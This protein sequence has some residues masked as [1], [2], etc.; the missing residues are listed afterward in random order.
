ML[1]AVAALLVSTT[2][3]NAQ[4]I[5]TGEQTI[6]GRITDLDNESSRFNEYRDI[7]DG[8]YVSSARIRLLD[9]STGRY[10]N[11]VG[12]NL[13][14]D[15][16]TLRV[17]LGDY[18]ND[19]K[20]TFSR[21]GRPHR[22][23]NR[24]MTPYIYQGDGLYTLPS[25]S[26]ITKDGN[27]AT[28]TPSLVPTTSQMAVNDVLISDFVIRTVRPEQLGI[29]RDLNELT[30]GYAPSTD[31]ALYLTLSDERRN[32]D[33]IGYGPIGDRP[34]R[35]LNVQL[36]E[37]VDCATREVEAGLDFVSRT[38]QASAKYT[39]SAFQ[40]DVT[41]WRWQNLF[42]APDSGLDYVAAVAGTPRN[43]SSFGQKSLAPDNMAHHAS[44]SVGVAL[45]MDSRLTATGVMGLANQNETLLPYSYSSLG[46]DRGALTG[47]NKAWN[48]PSKLPRATADAEMLTVRLNVDYAISPIA[49]LN[50]RV[51]GGYEDLQNNT[52]VDSWKYTT[53]DAAT[54]NGDVDFRSYFKNEPYSFNR[55]D[56]GLDVRQSLRFWQTNL[57]LEVKRE[58][59]RREHREAD[60][61]EN[62]AEF[63]VRTSPIRGFTLRGDVLVADRQGSEYDYMVTSEPF[64]YT[65]EQGKNDPDN[66]Q[67]LFANHPDLRKFDVSDRARVKAHAAATVVTESNL[68]VMVSYSYI[69]DDFAS[70]VEAVAPL[71]GTTVPLPNPADANAMTPGLQLGLLKTTR[72]NLG[73]EVNYMLSDRLSFS[74]F[75]NLEDGSFLHR[76]IVMNENQRREPS[77]PAIQPPTQLGPWTDANREYESDIRFTTASIGIGARY[78][79]IPGT[80]RVSADVFASSS[81]QDMVYSGYGADVNYLGVP[82]ETF[83]FG[84][85]DPATITIDNTSLIAAIE[86]KVSDNAS[87][88]VHYMYD[89]F[90][91]VDWQQDMTSAAIEQ[92]GSP[93]FVRDVTRDN[94]WGNRLV[95]MGGNLAPGYTFH[96]ASL[97]LR[98]KF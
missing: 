9:T 67:F 21:V 96:G 58:S 56:L 31:L 82:W 89:T 84:W 55:L 88:A 54:T 16:Q 18:G 75:G 43:V 47:D 86:Y 66:P 81:E 20:V 73:A 37:P 95:N 4:I 26:G 93:Y 61:D 29:Q 59:V 60:T 76:G 12:T 28:G 42:F 36:P 90:A 10:L 94:R 69:S 62:S 80:L 34:P 97:T 27:D 77:D 6:G 98:Y 11:V 53:N 17:A 24:A 30:F 50:V 91:I 3:S 41:S 52:L 46:N 71:A 44:I 22:F 38:V 68:D 79:L 48:D 78:D 63:T 5:V 39:F 83:A 57:G 14:R 92:V 23:S 32:G 72:G 35:T 19:W 1:L 45:P 7:R 87:F 49:G 15:D 25:T 33:K 40:N 8:F 64:W 74:L 13:L 51:F 2:A 70:N 85:D 65:F